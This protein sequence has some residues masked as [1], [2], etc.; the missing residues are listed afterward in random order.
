MNKIILELDYRC[1]P[2]WIYNADGGV[3]DND[4]VPEL[5][6][7]S[8]IDQLLENIQSKF[9][10]LYRDTSSEFTYV[11]FANEDERQHFNQLV[12]TA[13]EQISYALKGRYEI[14]NLIDVN[15]M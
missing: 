14:I 5:K 1:Y 11:G 10:S 7:Y 3:V 13:E 6:E 15:N 4:L 9:D 2:M 12:K 8:N